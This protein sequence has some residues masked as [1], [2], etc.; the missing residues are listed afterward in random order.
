[1]QKAFRKRL[2][3]WQKIEE[4]NSKALRDFADFLQACR[5]ATPQISILGISNDYSENQKTFL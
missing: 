3:I 2:E 4:E 1:M 5:D